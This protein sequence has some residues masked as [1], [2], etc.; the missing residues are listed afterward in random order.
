LRAG[1]EGPFEPAPHST[2]RA[3]IDRTQ[4]LGMM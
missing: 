3:F 2:Q 4:R 1:S